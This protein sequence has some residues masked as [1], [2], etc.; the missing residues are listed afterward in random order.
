MTTT[1]MYT[2]Q[3]KTEK[4]L[5]SV[6]SASTVHYFDDCGFPDSLRAKHNALLYAEGRMLAREYE[7]LFIKG[8]DEYRS[9]CNSFISEIIEV[10]KVSA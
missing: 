6:I 3:V 7:Q 9:V 8:S 10:A 1:P 4:G 2:T 5:M